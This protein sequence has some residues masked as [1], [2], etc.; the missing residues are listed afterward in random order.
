MGALLE[1]LGYALLIA[2][3]LM[4]VIGKLWLGSTIAAMLGVS[5][6]ALKKVQNLAADVHRLEGQVAEQNLS[7]PVPSATSS[8]PSH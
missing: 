2:G 3:A 6:L 5:L 8:E 4:A 7:P 1:G